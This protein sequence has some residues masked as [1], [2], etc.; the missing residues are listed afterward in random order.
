MLERDVERSG[1]E[2]R[3]DDETAHLHDEA[4]GAEGV[5]VQHYAAYVANELAQAA[6]RDGD[7]VGPGA[8]LPPEGD[9]DEEADGEEGGEEGVCGQGG[10]VALC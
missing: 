2:G 6:Q 9:V 4:V 7:A 8:I 5:V 1:V 10:G 3:R